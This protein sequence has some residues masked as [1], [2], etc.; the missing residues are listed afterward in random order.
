[1]I[2]VQ[3]IHQVI[4]RREVD[5]ETAYRETAPRLNTDD[6][7]FLWL[8]WAPHGGGEGYEAVTLASFGDP[9][10][11]ARHQERMRYGDLGEWWASVEAMRYTLHSST[12]VLESDAPT[13]SE[14]DHEPT[15][16]RLDQLTVS[17]PLAQ[18]REEVAHGLRD[19]QDDGIL[20]VMAWW[21]PLLGDLDRPVVTVLNRIR[22]DEAF[23]EA[24][25]D[26]TQPWE[27]GVDGEFV[28]RRDTRLLRTARWSPWS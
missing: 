3:D 2:L 26:P 23:L 5:F 7:S 15:L 12:H 8:A 14:G 24:F 4:A 21:T 1:M 19:R 22:S 16:Y 28:V 18:A 9:D 25:A 6:A 27:G 13:L 10:A 11:L 20:D 17:V